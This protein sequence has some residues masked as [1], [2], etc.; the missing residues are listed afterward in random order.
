MS[1]ELPTHLGGYQCVENGVV[2]EGDIWV[3]GGEIEGFVSPIDIGCTVTT[4][5]HSKHH[6]NLYRHMPVPKQGDLDHPTYSL[7][8]PW[9]PIPISMRGGF[10][11]SR[12]NIWRDDW[13]V[14]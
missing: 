11:P 6:S 13:Y 8:D 4:P 2:E 9:E 7:G 5:T 1:T 12:R 10:R 14:R 3:R